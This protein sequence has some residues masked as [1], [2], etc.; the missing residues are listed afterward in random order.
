[1]QALAAPLVAE[2]ILQLFGR[3]C[4]ADA[5]AAP[6]MHGG[7]AHVRG[8]D[9][10]GGGDGGAHPR[11]AKV[12]NIPAHRVRLPRAGLTGE[13]DAGPGLHDAKC[14]VLVHVFAAPHWLRR[15]R[16]GPRLI[17]AEMA[18]RLYRGRDGPGCFA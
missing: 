12:L 15:D 8:R 16:D 13:E 4:L 14:L 11:A 1:M 6:G 7:A 3:E 9:T 17:A 10:G 2:E 18:A 5:D